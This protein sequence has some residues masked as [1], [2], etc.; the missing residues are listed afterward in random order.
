MTRPKTMARSQEAADF[1][2]HSTYA[3][4]PTAIRSAIPFASEATHATTDAP[5]AAPFLAWITSGV[6]LRAAAVRATWDAIRGRAAPA[7]ATSAT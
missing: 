5:I 3:A 6:I 4:I 2:I 7:A 1:V